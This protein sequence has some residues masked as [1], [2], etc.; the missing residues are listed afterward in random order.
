MTSDKRRLLLSLISVV[1]RTEDLI[2]HP[3]KLATV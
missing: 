2:G 1:K 3:M